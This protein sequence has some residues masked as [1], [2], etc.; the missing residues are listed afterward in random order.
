MKKIYTILTILISGLSL[1]AQVIS[2]IANGDFETWT[3]DNK[4]DGWGG[5]I[6][7]PVLGF[8]TTPTYIKE[9]QNVH[10]LAASIQVVTT[11]FSATTFGLIAVREGLA[12]TG[13]IANNAI[14]P[15]KYAGSAQPQ[16][17]NLAFMYEPVNGD[18]AIVLSYFFKWN[19]ST[20]QR[21]TI[22]F[23]GVLLNQAIPSYLDYTYNITWQSSDIPDSMVVLL[24][25][26]AGFAPQVNSKLYADNITFTFPTGNK[27]SLNDVAGLNV[28]PNPVK[29]IAT[30][31]LNE[32]SDYS[33]SVMDIN[34]RILFVNSFNGNKTNVDLSGFD[35]GVY[36][37]NALNLKNGNK[38]SYKLVHIQ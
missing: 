11:D 29:S 35:G 19:T 34:G 22:G 6:D 2:G 36:F 18:T 26:S 4:A 17:T 5:Y 3:N 7:A 32:T 33:V 1:N 10:D 37:V 25:S 28:F 14:Q 8:L 12:F 27:V 15:L 31:V 20:N 30:V 16:A 13:A 24:A 21:D 38:S 23:G 9:T